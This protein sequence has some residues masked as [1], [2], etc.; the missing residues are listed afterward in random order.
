M[1]AKKRVTV[2][3]IISR[4]ALSGR[5]L[6]N[7]FKSFK[8]FYFSFH[9]PLLR[10]IGGE[11]SVEIGVLHIVEDD[12]WT[13]VG[14]VELDVDVAERKTVDVT[15]EESVGRTLTEELGNFGVFLLEFG[16]RFAMSLLH[17]ATVA[18]LNV[19]EADVLERMAWHTRDLNA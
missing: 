4:S 15:G 16:I 3:R 5:N 9:I 2:L 12:G 19:A 14:T 6:T 13:S 8:S 7:Q 18:Q 10:S 1:S 11:D 17:T